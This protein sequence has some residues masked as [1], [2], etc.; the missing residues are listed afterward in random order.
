MKDFVPSLLIDRGDNVIQMITDFNP[1]MDFIQEINSDMCFSDPMLSNDEQIKANLLNA[2]YKSDNKVLGVFDQ[3]KIIGLF[4]F[5]I[6]DDEKY[7][8]MLVG[9][10]KEKNAYEEIMAYLVEHYKGY[11]TDFV[12]NPK[13]QLLQE[14]LEKQ[15]AFFYPEQLKMVL[16]DRV[17]YTSNKQIELYSDIYK[18]QYLQM[19]SKDGY[20]TGEKVLEASNRFRVL[21]AIEDGDVVGYTDV[22]YAF[23][24]NEPFD[25]FVKEEY[26]RNGYGKAMMAKAIEM[27]APKSMMLLVDHDNMVAIALYESLGF[28]RVERENNITAS[29]IL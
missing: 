15:N 5:L 6:I 19:H 3:N 27:N 12:Y 28:V 8:E 2:I 14:Q 11:K 20:W 13:N 1:Y 10:S 18:E 4:V 7:I 21:L 17:S 25:V 16:R 22:T 9:L 26:R 24:E 23:D 29:L